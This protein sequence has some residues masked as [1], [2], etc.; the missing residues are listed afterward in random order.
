[1]RYIRGDTKAG[2]SVEHLENRRHPVLTV[3]KGN[4]S[5]VVGYFRDDAAATMFLGALEHL[6]GIEREDGGEV[7]NVSRETLKGGEEHDTGATDE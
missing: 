1:M 6:M 2:I 7:K 4:E 5:T 3:C